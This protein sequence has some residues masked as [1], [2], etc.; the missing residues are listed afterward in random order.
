MEKTFGE[1]D[2]KIKEKE[3]TMLGTKGDSYWCQRKLK[4][5]IIDNFRPNDFQ[6]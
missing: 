4:K 2:Q 6:I 3:D 1:I 5:N